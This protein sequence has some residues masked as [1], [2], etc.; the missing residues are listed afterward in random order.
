[1]VQAIKAKVFKVIRTA[2]VPERIL[3]PVVSSRMSVARVR[4][5]GQNISSFRHSGET[6]PGLEPGAGIQ[7]RNNHPRPLLGKEG[8][9]LKWVRGDASPPRH[10]GERRY[11]EKNTTWIPD[12]ARGAKER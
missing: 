5:V 1:M 2:I 3:G 7:K 12:R 4:Q 11:P 6:C 8:S 9:R 10:T